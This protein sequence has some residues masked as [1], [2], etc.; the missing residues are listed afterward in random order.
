VPDRGTLIV[1]LRNLQLTRRHPRRK[2]L[3]QYLDGEL[4]QGER[5]SLEA[6]VR[7]CD[8]CSRLLASLQ[9]TVD[10]LGSTAHDPP[11]NLADSIIATLRAEGPVHSPTAEGAGDGVR[12]PPLTIIHGTGQ[13]PQRNGHRRRWQEEGR[14]ALR[15]CL[16]RSQLRLTLPITIL[17]GIVL[18]LVNMGGTLFRGSID[19]GVCAMCAADFL[20]PF[21]ALNLA[22]LI[23]LRASRGRRPP[24]RRP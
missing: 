1:R 13:R 14:T 4:D 21:I 7:A 20:V 16:G 11:V 15:Y 5:R 6:H 12:L 23:L 9:H 19:L 2:A 18:T 8:Q 10:A 17:A 24:A 22:L 3:S